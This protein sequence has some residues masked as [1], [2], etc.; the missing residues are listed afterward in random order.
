MQEQKKA[1]LGFAVKEKITFSRFIEIFPS[2]Q[3]GAKERKIEILKNQLK[4]GDTLIVSDI[5]R[6]GWSVAEIIRVVDTLLKNGVSFVAVEEGMNL[7]GETLSLRTQVI[8][9]MFE[10][11]AQIEQKLITQK[12]KEALAARKALGRNGGRPRTEPKKLEQARILYENSNQTAAEVCKAVG[13]GR[14]TL[15]RYLSER[16]HRL[17]ATKNENS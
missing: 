9:R 11:F 13:V 7:N 8:I 1:I 14:R 5:S 17:A 3:K 15:F 2:S 4:P 10:L 12:T 16:K 6:I